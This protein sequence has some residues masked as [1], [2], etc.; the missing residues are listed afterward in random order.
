MSTI[1]SFIIVLLFTPI[2]RRFAVASGII[3]TVDGDPL[4]IHKKPIALLGGVAILV[5]MTVGIV[6][7]QSLFA[8]FRGE[9]LGITAGG[10]LVFVG[11]LV[12]DIKGVPPRVRLL[13]EI[14]AAGAV[15]IAGIKVNIIPAQWMVILLTLFYITG[16][17]NAFN[18]IDGMDGL[19][20]GVSLVSCVGFF[21]LGLNDGNTLLMILSALLFMSLLGF[22]PYN[23]HPAKIFLGDAG[24]RFLGFMLGVMAV[25]ST[26]KP[27]SITNFIAPILIVGIPVFDMAFAI[28]RRLNQRRPLFVGDRDHVYDLLLNRGWGQV[29]V[30]GVICAIQTVL[31]GV[32]LSAFIYWI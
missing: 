14:I 17:I 22:L 20:A 10:V 29:K 21:F 12:D 26:S 5:G 31:V 8:D 16:A 11:G 2:V 18:V 23:F 30:W 13:I 7:H 3:D 24:S 6:I 32:G 15:L 25:M 19:C 4:K 28:L 9:L 27:Y 1:L